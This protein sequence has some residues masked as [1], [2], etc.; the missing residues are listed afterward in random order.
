MEGGGEGEGE[1]ERN[2]LRAHL[3]GLGVLLQSVIHLGKENRR[4][5]LLEAVTVSKNKDIH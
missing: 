3:N 2:Q 1:G 4:Q 5:C